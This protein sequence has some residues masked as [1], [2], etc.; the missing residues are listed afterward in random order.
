VISPPLDI[1]NNS[2]P[3]QNLMEV[4]MFALAVLSCACGSIELPGAPASPFSISG[5][6]IFITAMLALALIA[7]LHRMGL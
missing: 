7:L 2:S 3:S 6:L 5:V 4:P 1:V